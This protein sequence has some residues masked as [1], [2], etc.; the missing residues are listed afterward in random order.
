MLHGA[1]GYPT[2]DV[3]GARG[4]PGTGAGL[5]DRTERGRLS[6]GRCAGGTLAALEAL[7]P[8]AVDL[9]DLMGCNA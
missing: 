7:E 9:G 6:L 1:S 4:P 8:E 2:A 5:T 3:R